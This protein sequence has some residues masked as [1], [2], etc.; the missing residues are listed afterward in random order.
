MSEHRLHYSHIRD[1]H[2][3]LVLATSPF[4]NQGA[5]HSVAGY[6]G[7]GSAGAPAARD[8]EKAG[9]RARSKRVIRPPLA[10]RTHFTELAGSDGTHRVEDTKRGL[11]EQA[12]HSKTVLNRLLSP[13][14]PLL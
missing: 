3:Q 13:T 14:R 2:A 11:P 12:Q 5:E 10:L 6:H 8:Y 7:A 9:E 4:D 1:Q